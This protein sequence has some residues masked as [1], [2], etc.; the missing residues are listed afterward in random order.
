MS[1]ERRSSV[2]E[3]RVPELKRL[4]NQID[5]SPFNDR[6]LDPDAEEFIVG[7]AKEFPRDRQLALVVYLDRA[8]GPADEEQALA[9]AIHEFFRQRGQEYRRRLRQLFGRGRTSLVIG[10]AFLTASIALSDFLATRVSSNLAQILREGV[11]IGGWVAM[12]RP[13]E[14]F[15]YDWWPVRAEARLSNRL[16]VMPVHIVYLGDK[17][18]ESWRD[19][20]PAAAAG[21]TTREKR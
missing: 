3:V 2:I 9:A 13:L 12:W 1:D 5:P 17:H 14:V 7:W 11:S 4:F 18:A 8:A 15:L 21:K 16:S 20:W 10:L 19:D 6:D